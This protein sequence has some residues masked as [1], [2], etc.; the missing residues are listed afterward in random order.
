MMCPMLVSCL[1][2]HEVDF[3]LLDLVEFA[4]KVSGSRADLACRSFRLF[5]TSCL[6]SFLHPANSGLIKGQSLP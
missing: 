4:S 3:A 5:S 2:I 1:Y 6:L